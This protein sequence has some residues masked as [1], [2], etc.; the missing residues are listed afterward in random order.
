MVQ[1]CAAWEK[2]LRELVESLM[3]PD[4]QP[5]RGHVLDFPRAGEHGLAVETLAD[6]I[7]NLEEPAVVSPADRARVL[8]LAADFPE[9]TRIRVRRALADLAGG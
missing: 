9:E 1:S 8:D 7:G 4:S 5:V 3:D 6:W 2:R